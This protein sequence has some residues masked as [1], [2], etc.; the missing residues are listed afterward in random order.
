MFIQYNIYREIIRK[1]YMDKIKFYLEKYKL[2]I[3]IGMSSIVFIGMLLIIL[4]SDKSFN[5]EI[6]VAEKKSAL[7]KEEIKEEVKIENEKINS[8]IRVDVKGYV[9]NEGVYSLEEDDRVI[10]AIDKAGGFKEGANTEYIN[11]SKKVVDEMVIIIYSN[12][13]VSKFKEE[14]KQIIYIEY[15]CECPD[16]IND[17]CI[18]EN[19]VVNTNGTSN[20]KENVTEKDDKSI[21][22]N[23]ATKEQLMTLNGI[24][25]SKANNII[26]Y[27]EENGLFE[28]L[29]DIMNVSGIG[30]SAYSKIKDYIKL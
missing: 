2:Y 20:N 18:N 10:D 8:E 6:I 19:D 7:I 13:E 22:I 26:K 9:E 23:T 16:N 12:D 28:N 3:I 15:K 14:E 17:A 25:E 1:D 5:E 21:S 24:G 4:F 30:E 11:L 27:R 29:E